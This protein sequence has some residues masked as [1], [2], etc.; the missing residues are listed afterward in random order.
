MS[1]KIKRF[2]GAG[3]L[4]LRLYQQNRPQYYIGECS[5]LAV[6]V[7]LN[8]LTLPN[9]TTPGGGSAARLDRIQ[10]VT[11]SMILHNFNAEGLALA[12]RGTVAEKA[13]GAVTDESHI[14][15]PGSFA[16]LAGLSPTSVSIQDAATSTMLS[17]GTHYTVDP[18]GIQFTDDAPL[19]ADGEEVLISYSHSA[20]RII[21]LLTES[22]LEHELLFTGLNEAESN[23]PYRVHIWRWQGGV[24]DSLPLIKTV[25]FGGM[26][27]PGEALQD[28]TRGSGESAFVQWHQQE[29]VA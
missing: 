18:N 9:Y 20:S 24:T 14:A 16:P 21:E 3:K 19:A 8:T 27:I 12:S 28:P 5:E 2:I 25:S 7:A 4:H 11:T 1:S 22:S 23:L 10:N 15:A 6:A 26:T 17:A 13:T 29:M